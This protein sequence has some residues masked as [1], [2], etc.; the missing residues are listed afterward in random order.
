ML[1]YFLAYAEKR[2]MAFLAPLQSSN[3]P[4]SIVLIAALALAPIGLS[5]RLNA[6]LVGSGAIVLAV[7]FLVAAEF[8]FSGGLILPFSD[9]VVALAIST[10]GVIGVD[11]FTERRK[12]Q[13]LETTL[14]H[15]TRPGGAVIP[16]L[17]DRAR[18]PRKNDLPE[19]MQPLADRNAFVLTGKNLDQEVDALADAIRHSNLGSP[20]P[21]VT[22]EPPGLNH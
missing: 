11:S 19:S 8:A 21:R 13:D 2:D 4:A 9:P 3:L 6:L 10:G 14:Q 18:M 17:E 16:V 7:L 15:L 5:L 20:V 12:S 1:V 22:P